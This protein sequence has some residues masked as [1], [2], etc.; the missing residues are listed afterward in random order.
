MDNDLLNINVS[1]RICKHMNSDHKGSLIKYASYYGGIKKP[2]NV[3]MIDIKP[4]M[5]ILL[6]DN[7]SV[8]IPFDHYLKDSSDAHKTLVSMIKELPEQS[9]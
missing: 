6:V 8:K 9:I 3:I 2:V 4:D 7:K 1:K 5:M